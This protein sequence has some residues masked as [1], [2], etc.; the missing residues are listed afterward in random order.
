[1]TTLVQAMIRKTALDAL[2]RVGPTYYETNVIGRILVSYEGKDAY[3]VTIDGV[4]S[5]GPY[6]YEDARDAI[7]DAITTQIRVEQAVQP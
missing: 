1:M 7:I 3:I 6:N 2:N 4:L 5:D